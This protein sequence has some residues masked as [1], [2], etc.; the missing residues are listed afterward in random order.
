MIYLEKN[1]NNKVILTLW[2]NVTIEN[3]YYAF[4]LTNLS[5][6]EEQIFLAQDTSDSVVRYNLFSI[7][8]QATGI[9]PMTAIVHL[10][11]IG[12][13]SALIYESETASLDPDD[14]GALLQTEMVIVAGVDSTV[15]A[16]YR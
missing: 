11:P 8:E 6:K 5:T 15:N 16:V 2:E 9:D 1:T 13:W 12:Q 7:V 10:S 3:P 14:W 4:H